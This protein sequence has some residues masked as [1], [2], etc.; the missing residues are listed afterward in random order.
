[1]SA[2]VLKFSQRLVGVSENAIRTIED[3]HPYRLEDKAMAWPKR[4]VSGMPPQEPDADEMPK[5]VSQPKP[6]SAK[7]VPQGKR[8][9][10]ALK[11]RFSPGM[12]IPVNLPQGKG[13]ADAIKIQRRFNAQD[14]AM[15]SAMR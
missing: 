11:R 4:K 7:M 5:P 1:M 9:N 8:P 14:T 6:M 10:S 13:L 15:W 3:I 12:N 2:K